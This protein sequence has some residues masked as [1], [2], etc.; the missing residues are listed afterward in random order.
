M[1]Y[2]GL[3]TRDMVAKPHKMIHDF[4]TGQVTFDQE[5]TAAPPAFDDILIAYVFSGISY[6][7]DKYKGTCEINGITGDEFDNEYV[8]G[9]Q[10]NVRMRSPREFFNFEDSEEYP[11]IWQG[12]VSTLTKP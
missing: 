11:W 6:N 7:I 4:Q 12:M 8:P 1:D 10:S 9:A 5:P 3:K 2:E